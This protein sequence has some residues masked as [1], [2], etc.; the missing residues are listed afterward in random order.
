MFKYFTGN[1]T[2]KYIDVLPKLV[3]SINNSY[4]RSIKMSPSEVN[5]S[6]ES[7]VY[8]NLYG[9]KKLK[10]IFLNKVKY[11]KSNIK[12]GNIVRTSYDLAPFDKSYYPN[13]SDQTFT[14]SKVLNKPQFQYLISDFKG[15]TLKRRYYPDEL[16]RVG[17][18]TAYRVEKVLRK[19][20]VNNKLEFLV[21][22]IG[23]PSSENSWISGRD[24]L[25]LNKMK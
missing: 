11:K 19:R 1:G 12:E 18:N 20:K 16:Q 9:D 5:E 10:N 23:Y 6:N 15:D 24:V 14:V 4:H 21:K 8:E 2:G 13:W 25:T 22:W 3:K 17:P 7:L